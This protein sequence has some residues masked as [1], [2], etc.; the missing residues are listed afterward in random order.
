M[1]KKRLTAAERRAIALAKK[2]AL[3]AAGAAAANLIGQIVDWRPTTRGRV[4][5]DVTV[6]AFVVN[7]RYAYGHWDVKVVPILGAGSQWVSA[8]AVTVTDAYK[9]ALSPSAAE[10]LEQRANAECGSEPASS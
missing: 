10:E 6:A 5:I 4:G 7:L 8:E 1:R 3:R 9:M 2:E